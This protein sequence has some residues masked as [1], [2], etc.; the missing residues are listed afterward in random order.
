MYTVYSDIH[1]LYPAAGGLKLTEAWTLMMALAACDYAF[2]RDT[3]GVMRL[4]LWN[5]S[6]ATAEKMEEPMNN[7]RDWSVYGSIFP[8]NALARV[9]IMRR[10]AGQE[11]RGVHL[12]SDERYR[13]IEAYAAC[14]ADKLSPD[15]FAAP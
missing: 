8:D 11:L 2:E 14:L 5:N 15:V 6:E 10:F 12:V 4:F 7:G 9:A 1:E 13:A 3:A